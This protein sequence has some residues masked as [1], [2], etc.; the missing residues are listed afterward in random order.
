MVHAWQLTDYVACGAP[1]TPS[2]FI[3]KDGSGI[4][5]GPHARLITYEEAQQ[6]RSNICRMPTLLFYGI[7]NIANGGSFDGPGYDCRFRTNDNR[8]PFGQGVCIGTPTQDSAEGR[9][10]DCKKWVSCTKQLAEGA[11]AAPLGHGQLRKMNK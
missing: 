9:L 3:S 4:D 8:G 11:S 10:Y 2:L 1:D 6:Y 7:I 5:C